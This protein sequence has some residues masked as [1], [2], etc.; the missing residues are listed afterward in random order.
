[1]LQHVISSL[2]C[3]CGTQRYIEVYRGIYYTQMV[4]MSVWNYQGEWYL[5]VSMSVYECIYYAQMVPVCMWNY[6][7]DRLL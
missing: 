5:R 1:M 2:L 3:A 4:P 7:S 6:Q